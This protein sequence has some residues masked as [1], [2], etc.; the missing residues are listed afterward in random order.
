METLGE[1]YDRIYPIAKPWHTLC[2]M[3]HHPITEDQFVLFGV[4]SVTDD[5]NI[6]RFNFSLFIVNNNNNNNL[7]IGVHDSCTWKLIAVWRVRQMQ[8]LAVAP[9]LHD[10]SYRI[11]EEPLPISVKPPWSQWED[12]RTVWCHRHWL[13]PAGFLHLSDTEKKTKE[14]HL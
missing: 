14:W 10:R 2:T 4:R 11:P 6:Y 7:Q 9:G 5:G 13:S 8:T 3:Q 12:R 1:V